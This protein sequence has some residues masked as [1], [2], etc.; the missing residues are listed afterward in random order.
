MSVWNARKNKFLG[1][2]KWTYFTFKLYKSYNIIA[3][4]LHVVKDFQTIFVFGILK[5]LPLGSIAFKCTNNVIKFNKVYYFYADRFITII[6][7]VQKQKCIHKY[8][9]KYRTKKMQ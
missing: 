5:L 4:M 3:V 9:H 1:V 2:F 6:K 7:H 8:K